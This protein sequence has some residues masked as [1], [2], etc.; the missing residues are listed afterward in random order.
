MCESLQVLQQLRSESNSELS[1]T[2]KDGQF[3]AVGTKIYYSGDMA[4]H[5]DFGEITLIKPCNY[6]K[7]K[8]KVL[9]NDGREWNLMPS[10]FEPG[11]GVRF[12]T[13]EK[14]NKDREEQFKAM[15][16]RLKKDREA[17]K[18]SAKC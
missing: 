4:N 1:H 5:P 12:I 8:I 3:L 9:L 17:K 7:L 2:T 14:R 18:G 11:A 10:S 15:T 16:D 13:V 6:Y